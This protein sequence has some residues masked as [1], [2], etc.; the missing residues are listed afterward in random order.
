MELTVFFSFWD[1]EI[2]SFCFYSF[3]IFPSSRIFCLWN[4]ENRWDINL[5]RQIA[6]ST[7]SVEILWHVLSQNI[8]T[9]FHRN[10]QNIECENALYWK[11]A[12]FNKSHCQKCSTEKPFELS[13]PFRFTFTQKEQI[14]HP[15][16]CMAAD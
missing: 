7:M 10:K 14:F 8:S 3:K 15:D 6:L 2:F 1:M 9:E 4:M 13:I 12:E 16:K 5:F 11:I